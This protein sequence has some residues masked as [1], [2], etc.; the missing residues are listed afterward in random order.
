MNNR[1]Q[2]HLMQVPTRKY[3]DI[4]CILCHIRQR[5]VWFKLTQVL[6]QCLVLSLHGCS[7]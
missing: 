6:E 4:I 1:W 3:A 7:M 2:A 5:A